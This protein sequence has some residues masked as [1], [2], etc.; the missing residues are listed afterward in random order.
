MPGS[1][2]DRPGGLP[3][4]AA[5]RAPHVRGP[6]EAATEPDLPQQSRH[7]RDGSSHKR[8]AK[9]DDGKDRDRSD[10]SRRKK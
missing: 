9:K 10:R 4:S 2:T 3:G 8:R 1:S 7:R 5:D 6:D